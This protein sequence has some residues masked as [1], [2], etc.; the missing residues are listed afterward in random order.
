MSED[1]II[2]AV[3]IWVFLFAGDPDIHDGIMNFLMSF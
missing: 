1:N 3:L 2:I